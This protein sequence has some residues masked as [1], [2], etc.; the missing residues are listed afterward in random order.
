MHVRYNIAILAR[1]GCRLLT[2]IY[3]VSEGCPRPTLLHR[4]LYGK[5][6]QRAGG[7]LSLDRLLSAG[8]NVVVQDLRGCNGSDGKFTPYR[9]ESADTADCL[10]WIRAQPWANSRVAMIG[11]SY[12]G[13][14]QWQAATSQED[15]ALDAIAPEA[16]S[17][18]LFEDW[19]Y[20]AGVFRLGF[21][22][23]WTLA[24]LL[25][26]A[27]ASADSVRKARGH[28]HRMLHEPDA[29]LDD[30]PCVA[31]AAPYLAEWQDRSERDCYWRALSPASRWHRLNTPALCINGWHDP[32]LAAT[33]RDYCNVT[34]CAGTL[35]SRSALVI[36]PWRHTGSRC[37]GQDSDLTELHLDWFKQQ[38]Q[39]TVGVAYDALPVRLY[40][41]GAQAWLR[42]SQWPPA[43]DITR[44]ALFLH[45]DGRRAG[46]LLPRQPHGA[47]CLGE[48]TADW[49]KPAKRRPAP[50]GYLDAHEYADAVDD[51]PGT[52]LRYTS[53]PLDSPR[54][55]LGEIRAN[56]WVQTCELSFDIA[57]RLRRLAAAGGTNIIADTVLRFETVPNALV[58]FEF[59][60]G[61]TGQ[62]FAAGDR[63]HL[64]I[65][66][67]N[68]PEFDLN[69]S[70]T[71]PSEARV[72]LWN[73]PRG[74]SFLSV[75]WYARSRENEAF[76]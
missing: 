34:A 40:V 24:D 57:L 67:S 66:T 8:F 29:H 17:A 22:L 31:A 11:R 19:T 36:G 13:L 46:H 68:F 32:F 28:L 4:T 7:S 62:Y 70:S 5:E 73:A 53:A 10:R 20:S 16:C 43:A 44:E 18:D 15:L 3:A 2:D 51:E 50:H 60:L 58:R 69:R 27:T 12:A 33:L 65:T 42:L 75:P 35:G 23:Y 76:L 71:N 54:I 63:L 38:C 56:A 52:V 41:M 9:D 37:A 55:L 59:V 64:E 49:R 21:A 6:A 47:A 72:L 25:P 61:A 74:G 30:E 48:M 14:T 45:G 1:D 26:H 39:E